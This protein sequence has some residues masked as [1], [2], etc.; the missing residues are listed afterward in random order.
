MV[1]RLR[2]QASIMGRMSSVPCRGAEILHAAQLSQKIFLKK[3]L[4]LNNTDKFFSSKAV[5]Y[6][7]SRAHRLQLLSPRAA[8]SAAHAPRACAP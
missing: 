1:Q 3:F 6:M 4:E 2:L 5:G 8:D 7:C